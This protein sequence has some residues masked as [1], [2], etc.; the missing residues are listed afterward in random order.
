MLLPEPYKKEDVTAAT[1]I[2]ELEAMLIAMTA[3]DAVPNN[4][5]VEFSVPLTTS[6]PFT[7]IEPER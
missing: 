4:E 6:F 5:P 1:L 7:N 2:L 3:Q